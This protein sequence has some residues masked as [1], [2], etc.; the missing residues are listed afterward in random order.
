MQVLNK[1]KTGQIMKS[2]KF[3]KGNNIHHAI[4]ISKIMDIAIR[5]LPPDDLVDEYRLDM[6]KIM[7]HKRLRKEGFYIT[8]AQWVPFFKLMKK[9]NKIV[10]E[11][12]NSDD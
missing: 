7:E 11:R 9:Y 12:L 5:D 8:D 4:N 10:L 6:R 2:G 1:T 3:K